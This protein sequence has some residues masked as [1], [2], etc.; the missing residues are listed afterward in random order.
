MLND[1][2]NASALS[3]PCSRRHRLGLRQT[4]LLEQLG[5]QK[6]EINRLL[7]VKSRI[8]DRVV[9]VVEIGFRDSTRSARAFSH[10]LASHLEVDTTG[11]ATLG[12]MHLEKSADLVEDQVERTSS[13]IR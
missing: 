6:G 13:C 11:V 4:L 1:A 10:I 12:L 2:A 5:E 8:A 7:G 3:K 9:P